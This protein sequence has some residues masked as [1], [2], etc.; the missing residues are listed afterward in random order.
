MPGGAVDLEVDQAGTGRRRSSP[1]QERRP[2]RGDGLALRHDAQPAGE[3]RARRGTATTAA[4]ARRASATRSTSSWPRCATPPPSTMVCGST[5]RAS[6]RTASAT[7]AANRSRTAIASRVP[8]RGRGEQRLGRRPVARRPGRRRAR[9]RTRRS[10]GSRAARTGTGTGGVDRDVP[11]LAGRAGR[12]TPQHA[13]D[14]DAGSEA[15]ADREVDQV[16]DAAERDGAERGRVD[17]V[18]D[19]HRQRAAALEQD[20]AAPAGPR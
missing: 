1:P 4:C 17:V 20:R 8:G 7:P 10:P 14:R 3:V 9:T 19:V 11:D 12:A 18:L 13:V 15:G 16:A 2:D 5:L 6:V